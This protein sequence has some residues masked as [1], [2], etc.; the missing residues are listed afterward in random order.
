VEQDVGKPCEA[1]EDE[2][3]GERAHYRSVPS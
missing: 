3:A 2:D 1:Q